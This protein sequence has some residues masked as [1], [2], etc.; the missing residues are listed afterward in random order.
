MPLILRRFFFKHIVPAI[1]QH[2]RDVLKIADDRI[3]ALILLDNAPEHPAKGR[4]G[5]H[6]GRIRVLFLPANTTSL[7][8]PL[9]QAVI[10]AV[11]LIYRRLFLSEVLV[12]E[13]TPKDLV[14]DTRGLRTLNN[15]R[16]YNLKQTIFNFNESWKQVKTTMLVNA[17]TCLLFV[18][19]IP[20]MDFFRF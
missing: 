19:D 8:Q 12:V 20:V 17:W 3:C 18:V 2:Q 14:E 16:A 1:L 9:D 6:N 11:K 7:I 15:L 5:A 13:E 4:L 10:H